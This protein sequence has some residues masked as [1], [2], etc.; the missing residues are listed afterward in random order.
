MT[1]FPEGFHC[2]NIYRRRGTEFHPIADPQQRRFRPRGVEHNGIGSPDQLPATGRFQRINPRLPAANSHRSGRHFGPGRGPSRR[3]QLPR[4]PA[5]VR[6]PRR[7]S[8]RFHPILRRAV[9]RDDFLRAQ[10]DLRRDRNQV[11][12]VRTT[13]THFQLHHS[14]AVALPVTL[15]LRHNLGDHRT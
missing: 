13:I 3:R 6:K 10:A 2:R 14:S 4:Q 9:A 8:D 12:S 7:E 15:N 11:W 5:Q 1:N